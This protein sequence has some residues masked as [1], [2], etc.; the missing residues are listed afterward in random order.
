MTCIS[1]TALKQSG[2]K[3]KKKLYEKCRVKQKAYEKEVKNEQAR[4]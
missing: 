2:I 3:K 1:H 4:A